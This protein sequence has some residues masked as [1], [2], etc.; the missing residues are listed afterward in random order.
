MKTGLLHTLLACLC[1]LHPYTAQAVETLY[2]NNKIGPSLTYQINIFLKD[3]Y[4]TDL[5]Q[6]NTAGIDLNG[7]GIE[8]YILKP[9]KCTTEENKPCTHLIVAEQKDKIL[10]LSKVKAR[11]LMVGG[12][13]SHGIKDILAFADKVNDYNFDIYIWSPSQKT[14]ILKGK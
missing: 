7:D 6:Y 3:T 2:Y 9:R 4:D 13:Q 8:E 12:T 1:L 14:Y 10:L 11:N 5:S